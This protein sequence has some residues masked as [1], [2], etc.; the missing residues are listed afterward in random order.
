MDELDFTEIQTPILANSSPEGAKRLFST[1]QIKSRR[2]LC[3]TTS[4]TTIQTIINGK[5]I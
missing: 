2:I 4:T 5:W 3:I 1:K